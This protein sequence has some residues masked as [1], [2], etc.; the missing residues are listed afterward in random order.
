[1]MVCCFVMCPMIKSHSNAT[2]ANVV[3]D[4]GSR[5]GSGGGGSGRIGGSAGRGGSGSGSGGGGSG[6]GSGSGGGD[7]GTAAE[8]LGGG[9]QQQQQLPAPAPGCL[10]GASLTAAHLCGAAASEVGL[11]PRQ[12]GELRVCG[13]TFHPDLAPRVRQQMAAWQQGLGHIRLEDADPDT[14][15]VQVML[16]GVL[17]GF[18]A[19]VIPYGLSHHLGLGG[20]WAMR[21]PEDAPELVGVEACQDASARGG[22]VLRA[23][24]AIKKA[25]VVG[26]VGGYVMPRAVGSRFARSSACWDPAG[27]VSQEATAEL[28][29]RCGGHAPHAWKFIT[30]W[31]GMPYPAAHT[32]AEASGG[33]GG[34]AAGGDDGGC[35]SRR[36]WGE[37]EVARLCGE[38]QVG[39]SRSQL[40]NK[41]PQL[42]WS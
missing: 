18:D 12:Q 16:S 15:Q 32:T 39:H 21:L 36:E 20:S 17:P 31:Y 9:Q 38:S 28:Q 24:C 23:N 1:M 37:G 35:W 30:R 26:V 2:G 11:P 19:G 42:P 27:L 3:W 10:P 33:Q 4:T 29:R 22:W 41:Q 14:C 8:A 34:A 5:D 25:S 6:G 40:P 13:L 7:R